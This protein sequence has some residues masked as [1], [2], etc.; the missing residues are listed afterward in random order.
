MSALH[1]VALPVADVDASVAWY[2]RVLGGVVERRTDVGPEAA[3][4]RVAQ[5]WLRVGEVTLNLA[6]GPPVQ[7]TEAQHFFHYALVGEP[8][9]LGAWIEHLGALGVAVLGPYGHGGLSFVSLYVDDPDGYRWEVVV[10]HPSHA[11]ARAAAS[12]HGGA[13]GNPMRTY[14]W[15]ETG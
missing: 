11:H 5:A 13:L 7:R 2:E 9:T 3:E 14:E 10:D 4:G 15:E 8:G 6:Q 1:H 12:A